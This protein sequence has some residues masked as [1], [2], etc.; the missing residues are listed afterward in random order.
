M[1][2]SPFRMAMQSNVRTEQ[3]Y[4]LFFQPP[5]SRWKKGGYGFWI[6]FKDNQGS[7]LSPL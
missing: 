2:S 4:P 6:A 7:C 3:Y 1:T 5:F